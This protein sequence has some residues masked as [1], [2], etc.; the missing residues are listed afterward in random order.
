VFGWLCIPVKIAW[1]PLTVSYARTLVMEEEVYDYL[2]K[3][4]VI[5]NSGVGK[6][7]ILET[8]SGKQFQESK[9][10]TIGVEFQNKRMLCKN[11]V[12]K[13]QIWDTAG[14]ERYQAIASA[15][16]RGAYGLLVVFDI[17]NRQSFTDLDTWVKK[18]EQSC[19]PP[20]GMADV[21]K[22]CVGN[23]ND[24]RSIRAVSTEEAKEKC[25]RLGMFYMETS[26]KTNENVTQAFQY[27]CEMLVDKM[28]ANLVESD[29][30]AADV[31]STQCIDLNDQHD[32]G[33]RRKSGC[34]C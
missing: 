3:F 4:V 23:K 32:Q 5:G 24:L 33:K 6:T 12:V 11:K 1:R 17:T 14:Q 16:F 22:L 31:L 28:N 2:F 13:L 34:D 21:A 10:A 20:S 15:Y 18:I 27:L 29:K 25:R 9:A 7:S 19:T 30:E 8:L 26:A